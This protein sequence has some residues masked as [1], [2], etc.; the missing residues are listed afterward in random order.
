[1]LKWRGILVFC[2]VLVVW[3]F[4]IFPPH[5]RN[6]GKYSALPLSWVLNLDIFYFDQGTRYYHG[7]GMVPW[8]LQIVAESGCC[9]CGGK[10]GSDQ[11]KQQKQQTQIFMAHQ[12]FSSPSMHITL[13]PLPCSFSWRRQL[14]SS[15]R[16]PLYPCVITIYQHYQK[17]SEATL[18]NT[19]IWSIYPEM[20]NEQRWRRYLLNAVGTVLYLQSNAPTQHSSV[21]NLGPT[22][23]DDSRTVLA[24]LKVINLS[25]RQYYFDSPIQVWVTNLCG[26]QF[27]CHYMVHVRVLVDGTTRTGSG[28]GEWGPWTPTKL[29]N[30]QPWSS[31][32]TVCMAFSWCYL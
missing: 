22:R 29:P 24:S 14:L 5:F 18:S 26:L 1:M 7:Y 8:P 30:P 16:P 4:F 31:P 3:V 10:S 21:L 11:Q 15:P 23:S 28:Q 13:F 32:F 20:D 19:A 9:H 6:R 17:S 27:C 12:S 25:V 2:L